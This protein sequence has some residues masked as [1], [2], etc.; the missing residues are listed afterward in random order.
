[1]NLNSNP[2]LIAL[3]VSS[4]SFIV[5]LR[6]WTRM[7]RVWSRLRRW[8]T[9]PTRQSGPSSRISAWSTRP[10]GWGD[11]KTFEANSNSSR[12]FTWNSNA[13]SFTAT[14]P[15]TPEVASAILKNSKRNHR[16][17]V[18]KRLF[19]KLDNQTYRLGDDTLRI[20][21][22]PR[23]FLTLKLKLGEYQQKIPQRPN[24]EPRIHDA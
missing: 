23:Q 24:P 9:N 17:P 18:A 11:S 5:S 8:R 22:K 12:P 3:S 6:S 2:T 10:Y 20:P 16:T 7:V 1:M 15:L 4:L 14:T 19:L 13:T 21:L